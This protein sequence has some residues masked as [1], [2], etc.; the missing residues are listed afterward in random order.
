MVKEPTIAEL[1]AGMP[2]G[3]REDFEAAVRMLAR[4][5][6]PSQRTGGGRRVVAPVV[7]MPAGVDTGEIE[8]VRGS[9]RRRRI[10]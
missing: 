1:I 2:A 3:V 8:R 9:L 4:L 6:Q 7:Q 5:Y 10:G